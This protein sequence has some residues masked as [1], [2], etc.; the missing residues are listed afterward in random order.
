MKWQ[1]R[2]C[3]IKLELVPYAS[4]WESDVNIR[5]LC[6]LKACGMG[7]P[8]ALRPIEFCESGKGAVSSFAEELELLQ[9]DM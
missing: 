3:P 7:C 9:F 2:D 5:H 4:A 6:F 1:K 8:D